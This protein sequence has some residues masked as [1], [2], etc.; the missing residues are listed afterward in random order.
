MLKTII[1]D[2]S[3]VFIFGMYGIEPPLARILKIPEDTVMPLMSG[4]RLRRL[5]LG[6]ITEEQYF[7]ELLTQEQWD[8]SLDTLKKVIRSNL[9]GTVPG[10]GSDLLRRL[11]G[12][13]ELIIL[14]DHAREW[15]EYLK[16][17]HRSLLSGFSQ[18]F[19]SFDSRLRDTKKFVTTFQKVLEIIG[20]TPKECLFVDDRERNVGIAAEVG[21]PG[22]HFTSAQRL[23]NVELP[24]FGV[25]LKP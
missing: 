17:V 23:I 2:L 4:S 8:I 10:M 20:R 7:Q 6:E 24:Q 5:F 14:S 13:Y 25:T 19:F 15:V 16:P 11:D 1:F 9:H 3:E 12:Q 22:I 21:I 18:L